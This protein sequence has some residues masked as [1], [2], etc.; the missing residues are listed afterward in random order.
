MK[1]EKN[2]NF[3]NIDYNPSRPNNNSNQE[4]P[5]KATSSFENNNLK[6]NPNSLETENISKPK[7]RFINP[8]E[9][10]VPNS[11]KIEAPTFRPQN[12]N[13]VLKQSMPNF[14]NQP[15]VSNQPQANPQT[16][17]KPSLNPMSNIPN[18]IPTN[19]SQNIKNKIPK[20]ASPKIPNFRKNNLLNNQAK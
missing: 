9:N 6:T 12:T 4:Q 5:A 10:E 19:N 16:E 11:S 13:D 17:N 3:S 14:S 20:M 8:I 15:P 1:E 7:P 2:N 18:P